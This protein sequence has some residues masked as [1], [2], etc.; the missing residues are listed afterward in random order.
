M[1][2][3]DSTRRDNIISFSEAS[4]RKFVSSAHLWKYLDTRES[5]V[6]KDSINRYELEL[7]QSFEALHAKIPEVKIVGYHRKFYMRFTDKTK[8]DRARKKHDE[9]LAHISELGGYIE[10]AILI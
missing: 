3:V 1:H 9:R 6:A 2:V 10:Q 8:I 4:W 5:E 7:V